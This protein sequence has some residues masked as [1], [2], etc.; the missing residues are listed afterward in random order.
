[1]RHGE[2]R[3][4]RRNTEINDN[5]KTKDKEECKDDQRHKRISII[6]KDT[7]VSVVMQCSL[8]VRA[9]ECMIPHPL[10]SPD[11]CMAEV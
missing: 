10:P 2:R 8:M 7:D 9:V 6:L 1:M 11:S 3:T 5:I 4:K